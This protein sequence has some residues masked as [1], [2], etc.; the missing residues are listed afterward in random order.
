MSSIAATNF[1]YMFKKKKNF[2][3]S[4]K[5]IPF[6]EINEVFFSSNNPDYITKLSSC[7]SH[8]ILGN[9]YF[10]LILYPFCDK[11]S[12]CS[13]SDCLN[14]NWSMLYLLINLCITLI[15]PLIAYN[16]A[17]SITSLFY[18]SFAHRNTSFDKLRTNINIW[19]VIVLTICTNSLQKKFSFFGAWII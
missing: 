14:D 19:A 8:I 16:K 15:L 5:K 6:A 1:F 13:K 3:R 12:M 7:K 11:K 10:R 18:C 9:P 4:K 2:A 17:R